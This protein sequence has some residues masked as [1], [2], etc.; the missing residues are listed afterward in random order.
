M[1]NK[2]SE[3]ITY[4]L[5]QNKWN[6]AILARTAD[7]S[8]NTLENV[9]KCGD[10]HIDILSKIIK[11]LRVSEFDFYSECLGVRVIKNV[12]EFEIDEQFLFDEIV[13]QI[14]TNTYDA[15]TFTICEPCRYVFDIEI[16]L[17]IDFEEKIIKNLDVQVFN[18]NGDIIKFNADKF[19][20]LVE[21]FIL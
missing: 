20:L 3:K 15:Q 19:E 18:E 16:N 21:D 5:K 12:Q 17:H 10:Y 11:A 13:D 8:I 4:F 14:E 7:I 1:K 6:K 2:I 9:L